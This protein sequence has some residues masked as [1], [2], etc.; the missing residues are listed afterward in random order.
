MRP[1]ASYHVK[2]Q[3]TEILDVL[4]GNERK[5]DLG[6]KLHAGLG[7]STQGLVDDDAIG[8]HGGDKGQSVG[9]LGHAGVIVHANP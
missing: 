3:L 6:R 1:K 9:E 7:A 5:G 8:K 4:V 2:G